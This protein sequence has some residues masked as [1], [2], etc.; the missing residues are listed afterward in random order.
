MYRKVKLYICVVS[1]LKVVF[2][3]P[4]GTPEYRFLKSNIHE[5]LLEFN[6]VLHH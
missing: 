1:I 5:S 4:K 2:N 3:T 6:F